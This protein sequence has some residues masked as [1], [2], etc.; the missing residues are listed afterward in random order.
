MKVWAVSDIHGQLANLPPIPDDVDVVIIAGDIAP[1]FS[2]KC[3][4]DKIYQT[5]WFNTVFRSWI[6]LLEKPVYGCYGN[7]DYG[8][9]ENQPD[10]VHIGVNE[11]VGDFFLF[12]ITPEF[13]GWNH[14]LD[15][16]VRKYHSATI[17]ELLERYDE[18]PSIWICH[19]PPCGFGD[20]PHDHVG[21]VALQREMV[22]HGPRH[23]F[24]GHIHTGTKTSRCAN[25]TIHNVSVVDESYAM[26]FEPTI[27]EI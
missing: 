27:L 19:G 9:F 6:D 22:K 8:V 2:K 13:C 3:E 14:M 23:V 10:T 18:L 12:A 16:V 7:H 24:C 21:S 15:D 11:V 20:F 4:S 25:T 26:V 17:R 5:E 1:N